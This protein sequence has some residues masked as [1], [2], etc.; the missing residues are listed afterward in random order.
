MS[1]S[2]EKAI[3]VVEAFTLVDSVDGPA[4]RI[5]PRRAAWL[6]DGAIVIASA[7]GPVQASSSERSSRRSPDARLNP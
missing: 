4:E 3:L 7:Y 5:S 6:V 2:A 1:D